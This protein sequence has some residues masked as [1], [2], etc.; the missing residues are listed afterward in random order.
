[1][2]QPEK[3]NPAG[4]PGFDEF[5]NESGEV[6]QQ[7]YSAAGLLRQYLLIRSA[8]VDSRLDGASVAVLAAIVDHYNR[9]GQVA[10]PGCDRL[11]AITG[12]HRTTVLRA[13]HQL[14]ATGWIRVDRRKNCANEYRI[15]WP[16]WAGWYA[17]IPQTGSADATGSVHATGSVD[18][19]DRSHARTGPVAYVRPE[20]A[21]NLQDQGC[22]LSRDGKSP[23][24]GS[25]LH[26]LTESGT[27]EGKARTIVGKLRKQFEDDAALL[28]VMEAGK[29]VDVADPKSWLL[30]AGYAR[31]N[32]RKSGGMVPRST[33]TEDD[34]LAAMGAGT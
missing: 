3:R 11:A 19:P 25:L 17:A 30:A 1:M 12:R 18:A 33:L 20:P 24:W 5:K 29:R 14:E 4:G 9:R 21:L 22:A 34:M 2:P 6:L 28:E 13:V 16:T 32:Q 27:P 7:D 31:E 15:D 10:F 8:A 23:I 26:W